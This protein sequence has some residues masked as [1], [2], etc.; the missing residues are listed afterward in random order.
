MG[1]KCRGENEAPPCRGGKYMTGKSE[2][3]F[4]GWKRQDKMYEE[5]STLWSYSP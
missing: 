5:P 2:N 1:P 4:M 3:K